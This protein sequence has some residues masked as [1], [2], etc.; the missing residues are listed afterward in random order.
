[1]NCLQVFIKITDRI[2]VFLKQK[3]KILFLHIIDLS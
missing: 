1:M 3:K 2:V